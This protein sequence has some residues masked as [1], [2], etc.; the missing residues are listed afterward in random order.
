[1]LLCLCVLT[2]AA[3]PD[4]LII[5]SFDTGGSWEAVASEGCTVKIFSDRTNLREGQASLRIQAEFSDICSET[6]CYVGITGS[7]PD[8]GSYS[9]IRIWAKVDSTQNIFAGIHLVLSGGGERFHL[10]PVTKTDWQLITVSFSEFK[11]TDETTE[12]YDPG[13][14]ETISFFLLSDH[15]CSV[16]ANVDGL[17]AL[18]DVN[19]NGLPDIDESTMGEA[20]QNAEQMANRYFDE[21]NFEKAKK[22]YE[23]AKSLYQRVKNQE[24]TGMM[25]EK[26]RECTA[27]LSLSEADLYY[28]QE[29]HLKAMQSYEKARREFI[30]VG[31]LDMISYIETRLEELSEITGRPVSP[32]PQESTS[33]TRPERKGAG[34]LFLVIII[35]AVV[36]LV[37]YFLKFRSHPESADDE[38]REPD[39]QIMS[40]SQKKAEEIRTLKAKFV[41]GEISRKEYENKLRELEEL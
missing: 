31:N 13:D 20:A 5:D 22:Y 40:P 32:P 38:G 26:T 23:E 30:L 29:E 34:G 3:P 33:Q 35:V 14:I 21:G 15:A 18:T 1:M 4:A 37:V 39:S 2:M 8:L 28:E 10:I 41:Y 27:F 24:K 19:G 17:I 11:S 9:F 12:P 36:G 25:D 16:R 6:Q 7:A